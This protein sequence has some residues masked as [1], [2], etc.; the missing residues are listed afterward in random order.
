MPRPARRRETETIFVPAEYMAFAD[1]RT[2]AIVRRCCSD[3]NIVESV[4]RSCYLQGLWDGV[5][6]ALAHPELLDALRPKEP[7]Q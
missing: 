5:Q 6:V 4:Q 2:D 1:R 3:P 7:R